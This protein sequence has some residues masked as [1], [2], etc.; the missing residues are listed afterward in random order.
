MTSKI[1][2]ARSGQESP[3]PFPSSTP[4][5]GWRPKPVAARSIPCWQLRSTRSAPSSCPTVP[6]ATLGPTTT[7]AQ[8]WQHLSLR[9]YRKTLKRF[10]N[11][12]TT[13]FSLVFYLFR[14]HMT[15]EWGYCSSNCTRQTAR[16]YTC[17]VACCNYPDSDRTI[18]STTWPVPTISSAG[19]RGSS[20]WSSSATV[21]PSTHRTSPSLGW[22]DR[23]TSI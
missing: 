16:C 23:W 4:T 20:R 9:Y 13:F 21:T 11:V 18:L 8:Q 10:W 12:F 15:G 22:G 6:G 2:R 17:I 7:G 5:V 3:A 19:R 14:S 1:D